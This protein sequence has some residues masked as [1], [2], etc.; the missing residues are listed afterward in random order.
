MESQ[1]VSNNFV[2]SDRKQ[3]EQTV[4]FLNSKMDEI[5][6]KNGYHFARNY[7]RELQIH[8]V[9]LICSNKDITYYIDEKAAI[10]YYNIQLN[11]FSFEV[12]SNVAKGW[13][14]EDNN[15]VITTHYVL[16]Y[17][18]AY[19]KDLSDMYEIEYIII[20][21]D[22]IWDYLHKVGVGD[23]YSIKDILS[24]ANINE[25]GKKS[26]YVSKGVKVVHSLNIRPEQPINIVINKEILKSLSNK[27]EIV[28]I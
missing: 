23:I 1:W 3:D 25:W 2:Y 16:I 17:P 5:Y 22:S 12:G 4:E 24:K 14:R 7:D 8:G 11:T 13:F 19:S 27:H 28:K 20:K 15:Y 6:S 18:K 10:K 26:V 21:K 9:D